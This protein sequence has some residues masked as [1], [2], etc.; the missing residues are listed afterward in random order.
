[1][2]LLQQVYA[3][4]LKNAQMWYDNYLEKIFTV[5][6]IYLNLKTISN[7]SARVPLFIQNEHYL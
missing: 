6:E 2:I 5:P 1:M 4:Q 7:L 3:F